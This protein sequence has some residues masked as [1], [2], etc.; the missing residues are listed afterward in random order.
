MNQLAEHDA[1]VRVRRFVEE[2][3]LYM[4]PDF[5]LGD[6]DRLLQKGVLDSMGVMEL[7]GFLE[8]AFGVTVPDADLTEEHLGTLRGIAAYV[9]R[10]IGGAAS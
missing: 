6:D 3:F 4:R 5:V 7:L 8:E 2:S 1:M 9:V 10:A